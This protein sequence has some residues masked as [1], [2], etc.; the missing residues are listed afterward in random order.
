MTFRR[1]TNLREKF[2]GNLIAKINTDVE[3][4]DIMDRLCNCNRTSRI[5]RKCAYKGK[6]IKACIIYKTECKFVIKPM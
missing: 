2:R 3:S 5:N 1:F 6:C 4:L